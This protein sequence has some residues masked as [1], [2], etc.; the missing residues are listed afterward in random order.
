MN[1]KKVFAKGVRKML[2]MLQRACAKAQLPVE[3]LDLI[4]PHQANQRIIDAI[5]SRLA[6]PAGRMYSNIENLGNTSSNTIPLC[7]EAIAPNAQ[8]GHRLGLT[9]FGGGFTYG[10]CLLEVI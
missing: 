8:S 6:L 2:Q 10:A 4:V 5:E 3:E 1:G 9:A 7:L